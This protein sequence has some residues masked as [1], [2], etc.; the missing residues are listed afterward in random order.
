MVADANN[1]SSVDSCWQAARE[2]ARTVRCTPTTEWYETINDTWLEFNERIS[3]YQAANNPGTLFEWMNCRS[4]LARGAA[5]S[6]PRCRT[7]C[8]SSSSSALIWNDVPSP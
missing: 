8:S 7:T 5:I 2:N 4:H 3:S 1:P 6:A